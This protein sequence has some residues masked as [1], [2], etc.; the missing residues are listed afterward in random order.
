MPFYVCLKPNGLRECLNVKVPHDN[1]QTHRHKIKIKNFKGYGTS[2]AA[3]DRRVKKR[4]K[5][6]PK[7]WRREKKVFRRGGGAGEEDLTI[8]GGCQGYMD[9]FSE[10]FCVVY[11][12]HL[13]YI[14]AH[15]E[16]PRWT[17]LS[18]TEENEKNSEALPSRSKIQPNRSWFL[19][20]FLF[21]F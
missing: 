3:T 9:F 2:T 5:T 14:F 1:N 20:C 17:T 6:K 18:K 8:C 4:R 13:L 19:F 11:F 12:F 10:V 15:Q 7:D 21:F 16:T